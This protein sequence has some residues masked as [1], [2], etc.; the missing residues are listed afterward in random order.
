MLL[1]ARIVEFARRSSLGEVYGSDTGFLLE[2]D[3]DLVRAPDV[4]YIAKERLQG[5]DET[6]YLPF[7]PDLAVEV[8]SPSDS[9]RDVEEKAAM[10]LAHGTRIVWVIEPELRKAFVYRPDTPREELSEHGE[11]RGED[12]LPGLTVPLADCL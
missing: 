10:W 9:F 1:G 6:K 2:R 3:P 5:I 7:A 12:V 11:L 8:V 4:A